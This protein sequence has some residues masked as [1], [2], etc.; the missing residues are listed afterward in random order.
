MKKLILFL[1][2]TILLVGCIRENVDIQKEIEGNTYVLL[3]TIPKSEVNITFTNESL[4]GSSGVNKYFATYE[5]K[6]DKIF[7]ANSGATKMM[8]PKDLNDQEEKFL[9]DLNEAK[10]ILLTEDKLILITSSGKKL[11]FTKKK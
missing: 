7:I 10:E 6:E 2:T 5:L 11:N 8:G 4:G 3:N 1:L 9:K